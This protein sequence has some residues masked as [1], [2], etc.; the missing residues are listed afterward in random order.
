MQEIRESKKEPKETLDEAKAELSKMLEHFKRMSS[1]SEGVAESLK[2]TDKLK[3][4]SGI[5]F[6][7]KRQP[8]DEIL[9]QDQTEVHCLQRLPG[10]QVI[11]NALSRHN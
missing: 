9:S 3:I 5:A 10:L 8:Y 1:I 7:Q 2:E 4:Q 6:V 11:F